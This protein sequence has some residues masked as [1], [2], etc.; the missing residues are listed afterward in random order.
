MGKN[1]PQNTWP[2]F[3]SVAYANSAR[4]TGQVGSKLYLRRV[5]GAL[6]FWCCCS[7][8]L[9]CCCSCWR[10]LTVSASRPN[11]CLAS[12]TLCSLSGWMILVLVWFLKRIM[13]YIF[14]ICR[15]DQS[16][17]ECSYFSWSRVNIKITKWSN[18][19]IKLLILEYYFKL[20]IITN[21]LCNNSQTLRQ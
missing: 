16:I 13:T 14:S 10:S 7:C 17:A 19:N 12:K 9:C 2:Q 8:W 1:L 3:V 18:F 11:L 4:Q 21:T 20:I 15:T 6:P 5:G